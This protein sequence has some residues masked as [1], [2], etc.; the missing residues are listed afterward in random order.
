MRPY[1]IV[2]TERI[3]QKI[4][5]STNYKQLG[6]VAAGGYVWHTTGSGKTLTCSRPRSSPQACR[7]STRCCSSSTARISTTRRCASTTASRRARRTPTPRPRVLKKQLEDPDAK[8]IITTIQKLATF[9]A[10][11]Q[12]P[13]DLRRPR[14]DHLRRVPPL[15]VR[16]HAHR[17]HQGVQALQPVRLHRHADLRRQRTTAATRAAHHGAGLRLL[18]AWRPS[19]CPAEHQM[20]STPTRSSTRSTTRTCCRS[21]STTSTP[22]RCPTASATSRSRPSTPSEAL[23]APERVRQVVEYTLEHFDQK[24]KRAQL[25]LRSASKRVARLQRAVRDGLDRRPAKR[26][27]TEFKKQQAL[28]SSRARRHAG[29]AAEGRPRSTPTPPTRTSRTTASTRR[30][31]RPTR[32]T[33]PRA[34]SSRT[35]SRTTTRLFG[36]SFDTSADKFQNYYKDLSLR[37]KNREIDLV[38]VVNMFLT[39]FDATTLN[40]LWVDKNLRA[41]RPDP[42]VLAHQPHPELGQDLRQHRLLPRPGGRDQR[43]HRAVRQQGRPRHRAAQA[44][45]RVLRRVRREGHRAAAAVPARTSRSSARA[46][47]RS[48]S[49]CSARSCGCRTS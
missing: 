22:S 16:R 3:L 14:R 9:I 11:E 31:S 39:G 43:R 8:I 44:V 49:R 27:Y 19:K 34:T 41:P 24:T 37:L 28:R 25:L 40:T 2:A 45:R 21:A 5:I 38:I 48:S 1:Q 32:S 29:P 12:G 47:R 33:S 17:D 15:A 6:T 18:L 26:Y 30:A 23:L 35:R 20:A 10:A 42:G 13:R 46:R 7:A 4:E 36:T